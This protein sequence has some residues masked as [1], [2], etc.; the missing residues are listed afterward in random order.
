MS[1]NMPRV[2]VT[3]GAGYIGSHACKALAASGY[4]PVVYDSLELG[5][6][7]AVRWG[8]IERGCILDTD[9]LA[10]T[11]IRYKIESVMHFAAYIQAGESVSDP[12]KY[13]R[14]NC[15]GSLSLLDAMRN[16]KV[17]RIVFSS[18]AAVYGEPRQ[19]PIPEDHPHEPVN[20]YGQSKLMVER[21]LADHASAHGM[22]ATALRYFNAAGADPGGK[23][24]E[25]HEPE[26]HLIPIVLDV[27][28]GRRQEVT[29]FGTDYTTP[30]G[31]CIRDYIHV[32]DLA[33]AHVKALERLNA[34][35]GFAAFNLG[36]GRGYSVKEVIE[37]AERVT[38]KK[39]AVK[40]GARRPG[41][42]PRLVADP[43]KAMRELNW[44]PVRSELDT[45]IADA[46]AWHQRQ[47]R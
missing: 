12:S 24:G 25:D 44:K 37:T 45:Q 39:I 1:W 13:Y 22:R 6:D 11:M 32:S 47:G 15:L 36:S 40:Y 4:E 26:S 42:P 41:D 31:T 5:H 35:P 46:W 14:N 43:A 19:I 33:A 10:E 27:A 20:P 34:Q 9:Q 23:I 21:M 7:W 38:G 2:L 18:T 28:R 8:P 30:D 16:A 17:G 29:V 3:G